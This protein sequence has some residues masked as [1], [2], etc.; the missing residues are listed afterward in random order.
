MT[1]F[2][3]TF[4]FFIDEPV[5]VALGKFDGLHQGHRYLLDALLAG[6][7]EGCRSVAFT[8]DIPPRALAGGDRNVLLTNREKEQIFDE[9]G[10]DTVVECPFTD[11]IRMMDPEAFLAFLCA[12]MEVRRIVAGTDF[13][14]GHDRRGGVEDLARLEARWGYRTVVVDK[15][16]DHGQDISSTRIRDALEGGALDEAN[17]LLGYPYFLT[18]PVIHGDGFGQ[19]LG[20]PTANQRPPEEKILPPR[21]VY[22][23]RV[24]VGDETF[25]GVSDIGVKPTVAERHSLGVE[26][27]ILGF[28]RPLYDEEIRVAFLAWLRPEQTF[29]TVDEL[30]SQIHRDCD[31]AAKIG[32]Q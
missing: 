23:T 32:L 30:R 24:T 10:I 31:R 7:E 9:S 12:R 8:F 20:I 13:R 18:A 28:D 5:A 25:P 16:Q 3:D 17:R 21:G 19:T 26:T 14:F 6:T 22:A 4:D 27:H 1:Y 29:E 2:T 11:E 15:V